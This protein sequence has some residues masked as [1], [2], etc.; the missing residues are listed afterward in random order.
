MQ[1]VEQLL[2]RS[3]YSPCC[4]IAWP[5]SPYDS[6]LDA[7]ASMLGSPSPT[8]QRN[9]TACNTCSF[10]TRQTLRH[11]QSYF[12]RQN[13]AKCPLIIPV[14]QAESA[15]WLTMALALVG[16]SPAGAIG[17]LSSRQALPVT[18]DQPTAENERRNF[19]WMCIFPLGGRT[20]SRHQWW[21]SITA[22]VARRRA[23]QLRLCRRSAWPAHGMI[24]VI[25]GLPGLSKIT[26]PDFNAT[27]AQLPSPGG[28]REAA[29]AERNPNRCFVM[30]H[31][32]GA[33]NAAMLALDDRWLALRFEQGIFP[34]LDRPLSGPLRLYPDHQLASKNRYSP[35]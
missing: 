5:A 23:R 4:A 6:K 22:V 31:S 18:A 13:P 24:G 32:A 15:P 12:T 35:S 29:M 30:G 10:V 2:H 27:T 8:R 34:A 33:Y 7:Y 16:C 21:C 25:A 11:D 19:L 17:I 14:Y 26:Y 9:A 1:T 3:P 20:W 28:E